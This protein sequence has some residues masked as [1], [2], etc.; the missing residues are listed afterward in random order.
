VF[1][2]QM[3]S[4]RSN[5]FARRSL[6]G[7]FRTLVLRSDPHTQMQVNWTSP[8]VGATKTLGVEGWGMDLRKNQVW[9]TQIL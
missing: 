9:H 7:F 8:E 2:S 5:P 1:P 6:G 3:E 4:E